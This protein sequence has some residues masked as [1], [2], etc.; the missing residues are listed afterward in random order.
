MN[1]G[2]EIQQKAASIAY[3]A[4]NPQG[5]MLYEQRAVTAILEGNIE[6]AQVWATL[7]QAQAQQDLRI[8]FDRDQ[9]GAT[10]E[11][12]D[13]LSNGLDAIA[14]ALANGLEDVKVGLKKAD[15]S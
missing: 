2:T 15:Q 6:E 5:S 13:A 1:Q 14:C 4:A 7:A 9:E 8:T 11:I 3:D 12:R 10:M